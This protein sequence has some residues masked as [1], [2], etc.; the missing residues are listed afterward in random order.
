MGLFSGSGFFNPVGAAGDALGFGAGT[1]SMGDAFA[2]ANDPMD[3]MGLRAGATKDEVSGIQMTGANEAIQQQR[4]QYQRMQDL[5][6]PYR[7]AG[8]QGIQGLSNMVMGGGNQP[9]K[10]SQMGQY[11]R[12]LGE[13]G[14]ANA[15]TAGGRSQSSANQ[16]AH[17]NFYADLLGEDVDRQLG[18]K[19]DM[20]RM[21]QGAAGA[22]GA[23][24]QT[25][26]QNIGNLYGSLGTMQAQNALNFG[27]N[28]QAA[29]Q[30]LSN[31]GSGIMQF[32]AT[33]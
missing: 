26:Q 33:R 20:V 4:D 18:E 3:L 5:Y 32:G 9:F 29:F 12:G 11:Q 13:M 22:V 7:Q 14:L 6:A 21:A 19:Y 2:L 16:K 1:G 25:A 31:I 27:Q 28:R 23:A 30:G 24:G 15:F 10:L 8:E 17:G